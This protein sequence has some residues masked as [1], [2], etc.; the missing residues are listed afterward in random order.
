MRRGFG[1]GIFLWLLL[2][3]GCRGGE[4]LQAGA[5]MGTP[6]GDA[7]GS[8]SFAGRQ[9]TLKATDYRFRPKTVRAAP[10]E[11]LS[12]T[13]V[14]SGGSP[15]S[16]AFVFLPQEVRMEHLV[17]LGSSRAM[18]VVTPDVEAEY[19]FYCPVRDHRLKGMTGRLIVTRSPA[20][21]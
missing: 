10:G 5:E 4:S 7:A 12:I 18:Q 11:K 14:N 15:H 17:A 1:I 9:I 21:R 6:S 16:I 20:Q 8:G 13:L 3:A 19:P 2:L